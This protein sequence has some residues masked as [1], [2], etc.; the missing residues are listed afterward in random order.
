[1]PSAEAA[2]AAPRARTS[3]GPPTAATAA[4]ANPACSICRRDIPRPPP[5]SLRIDIILL[6]TEN[7]FYPVAIVNATCLRR[8]ARTHRVLPWR[9]PLRYP[10]IAHRR[11]RRVDG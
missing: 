2:A 9:L 5:D 4:V 7:S 10:P 1:G 6:Q 8:K 11:R 3:R